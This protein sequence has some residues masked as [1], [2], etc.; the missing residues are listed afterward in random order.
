MNTCGLQSRKRGFWNTSNT[1]AISSHSITMFPALTYL[2]TYT[3]EQSPFWE[4]NGF[5]VSQESSRILWNRN[6][7]HR[8]Y[9][10]PPHVHILSQINPVHAAI[11][12]PEDP[13]LI[14][15]SHL[16]L[17]ISSSLFPSRFPTKILY[18]P[19]FSSIRTTCPVHPILLDYITRIIFGTKY[20]SESSSLC[21]LL[22]SPN[23]S[24]LLGPNILLSTLLSNTLSLRSS[25][26]VSDQGSYRYKTTGKIIF[27]SAKAKKFGK[28][29]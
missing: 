21:S 1:S 28:K 20:R 3:M 26:S 6:V 2:F 5:S 27:S 17:G 22:H 9:K 19:L 23:T 13:I 4:A 11:P 25:F 24:A 7:H 12:F 29:I 16:G 15:H 8:V 14:L 10:S 18:T